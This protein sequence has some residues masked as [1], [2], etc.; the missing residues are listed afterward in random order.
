MCALW[1]QQAKIFLLLLLLIIII[2]IIHHHRHHYLF[3][4]TK[5][6]ARRMNTTMN[7]FI[8]ALDRLGSNFNYVESNIERTA[9]RVLP[10]QLSV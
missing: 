5:V 1:D 10:L 4:L 9:F 2:I 7:Y 6:G 3:L 8:I